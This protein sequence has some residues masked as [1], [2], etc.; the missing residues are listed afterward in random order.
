MLL[1]D[2][3]L[4]VHMV[5]R[6]SPDHA[7]ALSWWQRMETAGERIVLPWLTL[8]AFVRISTNARALAKPLTL[9]EALETMQVFLALPNVT[10]L[11][12]KNEHAIEF[13]N[14]CQS[15]GATGNLVTDAHLAAL[16]IEHD[17]ELDSCDTDFANFPNLR[18]IN[19][20]AP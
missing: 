8:V 13:T 10:V 17:C 1:V 20:L 18:W 6:T 9:S 7:T 19:P 5:N 4:L 14:A 3:N 11:H 16:A 2:V 12:P 15:A